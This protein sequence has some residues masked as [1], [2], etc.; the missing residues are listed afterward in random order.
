[1]AVTPEG[2]LKTR[3]PP[4]HVR[5]VRR[6]WGKDGMRWGLAKGWRKVRLGKVKKGEGEM[7]YTVLG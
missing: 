2:S 5:A 4:D 3:D 1:M 7:C 6:E